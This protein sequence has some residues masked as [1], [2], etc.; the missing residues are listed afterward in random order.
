VS[1]SEEQIVPI[2]IG[3][4]QCPSV[5][6]ITYPALAS[7][8][9]VVE[10]VGRVEKLSTNAYPIRIEEDAY[11]RGEDSKGSLACQKEKDYCRVE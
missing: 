1:K 2:D 6:S 5:A 7:V 3:A 10:L 4:H 9:I 11:A 8:S